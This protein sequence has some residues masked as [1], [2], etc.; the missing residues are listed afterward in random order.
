CL[1]PDCPDIRQ[2][3]VRGEYRPGITECP[4]CGAPLREAISGPRERDTGLFDP[5]VPYASESSLEDH[6]LVETYPFPEHAQL[7]AKRLVAEGLHPKLILA[8]YQ[9]T[10]SLGQGFYSPTRLIV[11][12]EEADDARAL[13]SRI[14]SDLAGDRP[15]ESGL[16]LMECDITTLPVDAIV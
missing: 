15:H 8:S 13:L 11:P 9:G 14:R 1:N 2:L 3:G 10:P 5:A 7:P 16:T 12:V 4:K 6:V